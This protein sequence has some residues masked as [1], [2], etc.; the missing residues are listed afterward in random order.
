MERPTLTQSITLHTSWHMED[1]WSMLVHLPSDHMKGPWSM[2]GY[3]LSDHVEGPWLVLV[4]L[5]SDPT[6]LFLRR[7]CSWHLS[8]NTSR[9]NRRLNVLDLPESKIKPGRHF[10]YQGI[11]EHH[12]KWRA[13]SRLSW[14]LKPVWGLWP[15]QY[16]LSHSWQAATPDL[17]FYFLQPPLFRRQL[18]RVDLISLINTW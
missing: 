1:P 15:A 11:K 13:E 16:S 18:L 17:Q 7:Y 6:S 4:H 10:T 14:S 9:L 3:F 8:T 12:L 2:S 5:P